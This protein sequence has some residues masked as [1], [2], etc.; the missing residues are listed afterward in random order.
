MNPDAVT[1]TIDRAESLAPRAETACRV[2][3][4]L[5]QHLRTLARTGR[6]VEVEAALTDVGAAPSQRAV[7]DG[8][9]AAYPTLRGAIRDAG[10]GKRRP[11]VRFFA[12]GQ[13]LSH[14]PADAP[15]PEAVARGVEPFTIVGAMAGG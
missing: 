15:L 6:V 5:P 4:V 13:D 7:L 3:V 8:L 12:C 2:R 10:S 11:L 1:V 14:E 9:E